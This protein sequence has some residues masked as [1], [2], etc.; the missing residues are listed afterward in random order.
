MGG[1]MIII[2]FGHR[3][4]TGKDSA[5]NFLV[6]HLRI[7]KRNILVRKIGFASK[8]KAMCH[9]LY[10][11]AGLQDEEY[12]E[13]NPQLKDVILSAIGK[14]PREVWIEFGTSVGRTIYDKTWIVYPLMQKVDYLLI[15]DVRFPNEGDEIITRGGYVFRVDNPRIAQSNDVADSAM[16]DWHGWAGTIVNDADM[17]TLNTRTIAAFQ[18]VLK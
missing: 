12:Y 10:G 5:A 13:Q 11:W 7:S 2:G 4:F 8:M 6:T 3:R 1:S 18:E 9:D 17:G 16:K 15:K 14:S